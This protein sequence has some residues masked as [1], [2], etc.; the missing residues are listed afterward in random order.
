M[1]T[2]EHEMAYSIGWD[3]RPEG[4]GAFQ[5]VHAAVLLVLARLALIILGFQRTA[6][7][8]NRFSRANDPRTN[9][10]PMQVRASKYAVS[11]A[12]AFVPARILC[13]ERSLVLY[14]KLK[15]SGVP[16]ALRLGVRAY[17]F[18]A[19]AWVELEGSPV[20]ETPDF[21]KDFTPILEIG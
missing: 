18:A 4:I 11:L 20:N 6:A 9:M 17:P 15:R 12:A 3:A 21:L 8:V 19:H 14:H 2:M 1:N 13:L 5:V 16:V 7:I 10:N